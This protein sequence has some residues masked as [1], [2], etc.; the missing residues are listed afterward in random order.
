VRHQVDALQFRLFHLHVIKG[1]A[2]NEVACRLEVKLPSVYFAK[3]KV[4]TLLQKEVRLL[5][6]K[7]V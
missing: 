1:V 2:A 6:D 3:Y 5:Q 4:S 7:F